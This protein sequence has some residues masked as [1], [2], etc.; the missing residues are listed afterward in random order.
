MINTYCKLFE[1]K[2]MFINILILVFLVSFSSPLFSQNSEVETL[3]E[4]GINLYEQRDYDGALEVFEQ[5]LKL[6]PQSPMVNYE[7][8]LTYMAMEEYKTAIEYCEKVLAANSELANRAYV[9]KGSAEDMLGKRAEAVNT[10]EKGLKQYPKD[11]YLYYNLALTQY[12]MKDHDEAAINLQKALKIDPSYASC[13]L[14]LG[15]L[16]HEMGSRVKSL[17]ALYNFLLLEPEGKRAEQALKTVFALHNQGITR[18]SD[19]KT[20]ILFPMSNSSDEFSGAELMI[21]LT[22]A[23]RNTEG[24]KDKSEYKFF[25]DQTGMFIGV[26]AS[27]KKDKKG[28]WWDYYVTFFADMKKT[29]NAEAFAYYILL[30]EN[31]SE[32][33]E[34]LEANGEKMEKFSQWYE[35]YTR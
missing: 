34:W 35:N 10:F 2:I 30:S 28:F 32:V 24:E 25:V 3:V 20:N 7:I 6:D 21:S 1:R 13:H 26:L 11:V 16:M 4:K 33:T 29:D 8:A 18:E 15:Y 22:Q 9:L 14:F 17:L 5:A 23:S 31:E 27:S 19:K 12:K